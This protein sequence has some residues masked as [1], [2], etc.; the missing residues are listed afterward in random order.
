MSDPT[1]PVGGRDAGM[2]QGMP[3]LSSVATRPPIDVPVRPAPSVLLAGAHAPLPQPGLLG[4]LDGVLRFPKNLMHELARDPLA[5]VR[6]LLVLLGA[7]AVAGVFVGGFSG[8]MQ[9]L[10]VPL[11]LSLGM[12]LCALI[13]FPSLH[14]FACL[15]GARHGLRETAGALLAGITLTS[16]LLV[17]FAP[18]SWVFSQATDSAAVMGG[19]HVTFLLVSAHFGLRLTRRALAD[20]GGQ[21]VPALG[22]WTLVFVVVVL[23]MTTTLRPLVG[24]FDGVALADKAFFLSHWLS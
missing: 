12:V 4:V 20:V 23:Q 9:L 11:K 3:M 10:L 1:F 17:G 5:H 8:G 21:R 18:V 15:S 24:P 16:V 6:V 13:C 22:L 14:V 7:M 2:E 19:L